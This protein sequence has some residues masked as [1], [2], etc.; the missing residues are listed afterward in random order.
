M[1]KFEELA[2]KI[3]SV[4]PDFEELMA[5]NKLKAFLTKKQAE[6]LIEEEEENKK[7]KVWVILLAIVGVIAIGCLVGYFI[8]K[9]T[10]P[11][12]LDDFEDDFEEGEEDF[13]EDEE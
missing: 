12:Y 9:K 3:K 6:E 8:Y 5:N 7:V 11:E 1:S 2:D 13:Y 10:Q 4:E